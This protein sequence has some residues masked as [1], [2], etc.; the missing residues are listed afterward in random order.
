MKGTLGS[1]IL[2]KR[3][4]MQDGGTVSSFSFIV[5]EGPTRTHTHQIIT[6]SA[7]QQIMYFNNINY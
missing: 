4:Q 6:T 5:A 7:T 3:N 1:L 2:K